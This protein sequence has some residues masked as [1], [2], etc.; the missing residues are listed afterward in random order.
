VIVGHNTLDNFAID[1][2]IFWS[3]LHQ[4]NFFML[5]DDRAL[6]VGYPIIP[7]A[8]V[9]SLGYCFGS[10]YDPAFAG[11]RQ[12]LFTTIGL[13]TIAAFVIVRFVNQYGN[14]DPWESQDTIL[15]TAY[16]FL[17]PSKYPPSLTYVLMTLGPAILFLGN[18]EKLSGKLV[19][20]FKVF[21][22]VPFFY[23]ILHL[24]IIHIG[25]FLLAELTGFGW[26]KMIIFG[27]VT[28][29]PELKGYGVD[30][31]VVYIIWIGIILLLYPLCRWF[32]AYKLK[33]KE[34]RWL[35]Y[36]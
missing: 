32:S 15:K 28:E 25:A 17:N 3:I 12:K 19:D 30:L 1:G 13:V 36:L 2:S 14:F 35:S 4:F 10:L 22:K 11:K 27:W 34:K 16:S 20:F 18:A 33:H 29:T 8:A 6:F 31:W 23:Y 9:M 7:W 21:G 24:Y 5:S 26:R